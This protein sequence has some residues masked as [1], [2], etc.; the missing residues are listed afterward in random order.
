M[1]SLTFL[2]LATLTTAHMWLSDPPALKSRTNPYAGTDI[3]YSLASPLNSSGNNYPCKGYLSLLNT[4]GGTPV[5]TWPAGSTQQFAISGGASHAGG[6]CQASLSIDGGRTFRVMH[7]YVGGCP[8]GDGATCQFTVPE[9]TPSSDGAVFSWTWFNKLG[10][11]EMYQNCAVVK[12]TSGG[13]SGDFRGRPEVFKANVGNGCATVESTDLMFPQPGSEVSVVGEGVL[14]K[15]TCGTGNGRV[16]SGGSGDQPGGQPGTGAG[17][18][19]GGGAGSGTG[20]GTGSGGGS[21]P[22]SGAGAGEIGAGTGG[23]N[24]GSGGGTGGPG[25]P[26][27][28]DFKP[29]N[30]WPEWFHS[31][32]SAA[33][34]RTVSVFAVLIGVVGV[35]LS[36]FV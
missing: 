31:G 7:S 23:N 28:G 17:G 30:D 11:R 36:A 19:G 35:T 25:E 8:T 32:Q 6:S 21:E 22:G 14:P 26:T 1:K 10:N 34:Q 12:V 9:D 33:N 29:G 15:G 24:G 27:D 2:L 20:S 5:A 16:S 13:G 3:D 18:G 4:P